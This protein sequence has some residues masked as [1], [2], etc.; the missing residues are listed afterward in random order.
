MVLIEAGKY[1]VGKITKPDG[2]CDINVALNDDTIRSGIKT[3][4]E[5]MAIV[6]ML[7]SAGGGHAEMLAYNLSLEDAKKF[8]AEAGTC[9]FSISKTSAERKKIA[10]EGGMDE[11]PDVFSS[12]VSTAESRISPSPEPT[13]SLS[14][15]LPSKPNQEV[16]IPL[17]LVGLLLLL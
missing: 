3:T 12:Y 4:G 6:N 16:L 8:E 13:I 14:G 17:A 15:P 9:K 1:S 5:A 11:D 2:T 7:A 10:F